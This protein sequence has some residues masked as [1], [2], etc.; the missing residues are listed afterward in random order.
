MTKVSNEKQSNNANVLLGDSKI[1]LTK[2]EKKIY[3][4]IMVTFPATSHES[5]LDKALQGGVNWQFYPR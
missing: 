1:R 4:A 3:D 2:A 5:A